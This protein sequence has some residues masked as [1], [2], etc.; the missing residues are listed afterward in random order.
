MESER[1]WLL[2]GPW[3]I[4]EF[5]LNFSCHLSKCNIFHAVFFSIGLF[6]L[7]FDVLYWKCLWTSQERLQTDGL[8]NCGCFLSAHHWFS[9]HHRLW[10]FW[11]LVSKSQGIWHRSRNP[12]S[13]IFAVGPSVRLSPSVCLLNS[14]YYSFVHVTYPARSFNS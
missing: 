9:V 12:W 7:C 13:K 3:N 6:H 2:I 10:K 8:K 14:S 11:F 4:G 1:I 5:C